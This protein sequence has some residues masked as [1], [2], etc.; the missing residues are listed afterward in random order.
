MVAVCAWDEGEGK[1]G[2]ERK[3]EAQRQFNETDGTML[4]A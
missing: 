4:K 2:R 1:E 3:K